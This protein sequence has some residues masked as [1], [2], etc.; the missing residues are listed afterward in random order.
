LSKDKSKGQLIGLASQGDRATMGHA[1]SLKQE[2]RQS[3]RGSHRGLEH[4]RASTQ[5][6]QESRSCR[7]RSSGWEKRRQGESQKIDCGTTLRYCSESRFNAVGRQA[8]SHE[9]ITP[10]GRIVEEQLDSHL[11]EVQNEFKSDALAFI[12][13]LFQGV[14]DII[15][16]AVEF[17]H[18]QHRTPQKSKKKSTT[19]LSKR[20]K[21]SVILETVGGYAEVA[22]R[23]ADL[24]HSNFDVVEFIVPNFAYSAGTILVM[25]GDEIWMDYHSVLGPIDPQV[26]GPKGHLIPAQGYLVQYERLIEK[27]RKKTITTAE[28]NFLISNFDPAELYRYEQ[29]TDLSI[30]LLKDW[31]VKYKFRN[32]NTTGARGK[33]VTK[34]MKSMRARKIANALNDTDEWHSHG[35]GISMQILRNDVGLKIEDFGKTDCVNNCVRRYYK[36]LR[37]YMAKLGTESAVHVLKNFFPM[38]YAR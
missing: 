7:T 6:T 28:L 9:P 32:W 1:C 21:L 5:E 11:V 18:D 22:E 15:R 31:L 12:G 35:R 30:A 20:P 38:K 3:N 8:M 4:E 26:E 33:A 34:T 13:P 37:D 25:S 17:I 16:D 2:G 24:L 23:M 27:S 19:A 14:E 29:E 36:L 10:S